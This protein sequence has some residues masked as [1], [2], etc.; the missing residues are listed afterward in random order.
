MC[1]FEVTL[2]MK[3]KEMRPVERRSDSDNQALAGTVRLL[4]RNIEAKS[5]EKPTR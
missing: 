2:V 3:A 1:V 5:V 4:Q